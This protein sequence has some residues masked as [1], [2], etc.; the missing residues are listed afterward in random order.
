MDC[1]FCDKKIPGKADR[2]MV[3]TNG[4]SIVL[5]WRDREICINCYK[6]MITKRHKFHSTMKD[7]FALYNS[8]LYKGW[9]QNDASSRR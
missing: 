1:I 8:K 3:F 5:F 9:G 7:I 2:L 4:D 6:N